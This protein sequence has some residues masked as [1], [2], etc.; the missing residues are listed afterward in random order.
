MGPARL[1][2][3]TGKRTW[4]VHDLRALGARPGAWYSPRWGRQI[5]GLPCHPL[6][7]GWEA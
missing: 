5:H 3:G 6:R 1:S 4:G 7:E 2:A